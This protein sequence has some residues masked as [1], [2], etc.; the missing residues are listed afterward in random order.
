M[1]MDAGTVSASSSSTWSSS[2]DT[3]Y[4]H[5]LQDYTIQDHRRHRYY[6]DRFIPNRS[7]MDLEMAHYLLVESGKGKE[8]KRVASPWKETYRKYL[9]EV[10][11]MNRTRILSF[12]SK[13]SEPTN[14][15]F[16]ENFSDVLANRVKSSMQRRYI[17]KAP[18]RTLDAPG[19]LDD[20]NLNLLDW[21]SRNIVA[22]ALENTMYLWGNESPLELFSVNA[23]NGPLTSVSWAPDGK[24]IAV[25]L[26]S[27]V[28]E[29]WDTTANKKLRTLQ[30]GHR[31]RVGSLAWNDNILT[32]G[33]ADSMIINSDIRVRSHIVQTYR[34]H[35]QEVCGLKW[36][37]TGRQLASGG[38][39]HLLC[40]WE[41]SMASSNSATQRLHRFNSHKAT[42]KA[43][44]WCPF[45]H[46]M[47]ASGGGSEDHS[48]KFWDIN[49]GTCLNS[50]NTGSQ[51]CSLLW[52]KNE[53]ELLSSHA[54]IENQ[55]I[56]WKYPSMDKIAELKGHTSTGLF[57]AQSP[58]GCTVASAGSEAL[59][60]WNVFGT[61]EITKQAKKEHAG[62]FSNLVTHIR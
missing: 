47:I 9:A 4:L 37:S 44:A 13:P 19:L 10:M 15:I 50:F 30:G 26:N 25:G 8:N 60:L 27:S 2:G 46:N 59:M 48:I 6:G 11:M 32:S 51:V 21:S 3:Q 61:P 33:G 20:Y 39:D 57:M 54:L 22:I 35:H 1:I 5:R 41:R 12:W 23:E 55:L 62:L 52:S 38:K 56:L 49:T 17:R 18:D 58:D 31:G 16:Q 24:Y 34:G 7:S 29:L 36:S 28:V 42:V 53:R 14:G 45:Q 40:I 43:L